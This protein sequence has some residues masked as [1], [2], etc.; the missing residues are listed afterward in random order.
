MATTRHY[1]VFHWIALLVLISLLL[2][3]C[4]PAASETPATV[5]PAEPPAA[6]PTSPPQVEPTS[7]PAEGSSI[8][9]LIA[10]APPSFNASIGDTGY[11]A[12]VMELALLG[13]AD[14]DANGQIFPEL[15]E[16]LPTVENGG[17]V[18]DEENGTMDVT[19]KMRKDVEW[20]DGEPVNADDVVFTY[21]AI[22]HPETGS[23]TQGIDYVDGVEKIDDYTVVVHYNTIYP[24][25]LTQFGGEQVVI[26][27]EHYC[28]AEQ[29]FVAWDCALTPLSS[30]PYILEEWAAGDHL[31]FVRNP[32]YFEPGKPAID[33]VIV[34]IVPEASVR[35][36]MLVRG[37]GDVIMWA[38]EAVVDSLKDEPSV[39][40]SQSP[41]VRWAMR[42]FFNL[43]ERGTI[44]AQGTPHPIL[45]DVRVRQAIRQAIDVDTI[46]NEIFLGYSTPV[47]SEFFREPFVCDV[48]RPVYDPAA[49][50][51]LL[52]EAGWV[53]EDGDSVRECHGCQTAE[54]GYPMSMEFM[55]Y[56]EYGEPLELTQQLIGEML[57]DIG[58]QLKLSILEGSV[59]WADYQSGG[60]EQRGDFDINLWDDGYFGDDPTDFLWELYYS[61][62]AEPD[63][64][65]NVVRYVNEEVDALID[66]AYTLDEA[67]RKDLFCQLAEILDRDL[68]VMLM[69]SAINADAYSARL[70]GVQSSIN[71]IVTWNVA[72]WTLK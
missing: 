35:R 31:T 23:W 26:W 47:W 38:T 54:E 72:D 11:D 64:G 3:G 55:T 61:Q 59:L 18:V 44:D 33:E 21:D 60:I 63:L 1:T 58:I 8:T 29:G 51:A 53:D 42:L 12:L 13:L 27:P 66:S 41:T 5:A 49:A 56:S 50:M 7:P 70:E 16:Q 14:F 30:G 71:D 67:A 20:A 28:D 45:S 36:E 2:A 17:V 52:E 9:I 15:A 6:A 43:A 65:W 39:K 19:W 22:V 69:F 62:A 25:Y 48:P 37:D 34:R 68:P 4:K 57:A 24:G 40:I 32:N 10:E 46:S